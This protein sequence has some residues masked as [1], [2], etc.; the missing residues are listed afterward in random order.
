MKKHCFIVLFLTAFFAYMPNLVIGQGKC[1]SL[2]A[3]C[4]R[5]KGAAQ[6]RLSNC[7]ARESR[8]KQRA[9]DAEEQARQLQS[10]LSVTKSTLVNET[11]RANTEKTRADRADGQVRQLQ[12]DLSITKSTLANETTRANTEKTRADKADGQVSQLKSDLTLEK[13]KLTNESIRANSEKTRADKLQNDLITEKSKS[14]NENKRANTAEEKIKELEKKIPR[15]TIS[16]VWVEFNVKKESVEGL[17][18]HINFDAYNL[19]NS[20]CQMAAYFYAKNGD[21]LLDKN[22][23]YKTSDGKIAYS[24]AF[25]PTKNTAVI[26]DFQIFMPYSELHQTTG[27]NELK[28]YLRSY[29]AGNETEFFDKSEYFP[30]TLTVP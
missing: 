27:K 6:K 13:L 19:L 18:I 1:E 12:S 28:F 23:S 10:D 26:S 11:T 14:S 17:L 4:N 7:L 9:D 20:E 24:L 30:F 15:V 3:N 29:R 16:K 21:A 2:L 8:E 5:D 25:K 22:G